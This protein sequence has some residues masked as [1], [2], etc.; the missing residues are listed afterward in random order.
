[1]I[2]VGR[3]A[4]DE[5]RNVNIFLFE[6]LEGKSNF[7]ELGAETVIL[8]KWIVQETGRGNEIVLTSSLQARQQVH[9][10]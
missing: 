3:V 4:R 8:L 9:R 6:K 10:T 7:E 1:M 2:S 5:M